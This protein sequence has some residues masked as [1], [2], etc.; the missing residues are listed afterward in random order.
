MR[1][2]T[3]EE[4]NGLLAQILPVLQRLRN[5][6]IELRTARVGA[7]IDRRGA[8]ADGSAVEMPNSAGGGRV[9]ELTQSVQD[10]VDLLEGWGVLLKDPER[11]LIDFYHDRLGETVFLCYQ[12][13]DPNIGHWHAVSDGFAGRQPL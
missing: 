1:R 8:S 12:L 10:C 11:G 3:T 9:D 4:A 13:G 5:A 7:S 2:Y 6:V